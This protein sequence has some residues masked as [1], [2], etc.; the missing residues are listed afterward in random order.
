MA[1]ITKYNLDEES[2]TITQMD[3]VSMVVNKISLPV[4]DFCDILDD[5]TKRAGRCLEL[6]KSAKGA[7][8]IER[9]KESVDPHRA[10]EPDIIPN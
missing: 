2:V 5:M 1:L 6:K 10:D 8:T 3:N 9:A 4:E 7:F